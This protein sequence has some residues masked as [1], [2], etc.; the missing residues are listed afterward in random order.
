MNSGFIVYT[1]AKEYSLI[2]NKGN[3]KYFFEGFSA[4][5]PISL[6]TLES[7]I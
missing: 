5:S 2:E 7:V 4:G 3:G 6:G 1:N